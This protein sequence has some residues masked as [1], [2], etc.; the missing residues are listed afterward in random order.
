MSSKSTFS[1]STSK[2]YAMALYELSKESSELDKVE[3][4]MKSLEKI[5]N[6]SSDFKEMILNPMIMK[7]DKRNVIYAIS[8]HNNFP[9]NFKKFLGFLA[10]KNRLFFLNKIIESFLSLVS[11]TKGELKAKLISAK[12]LSSEEILDW[13]LCEEVSLN[14]Y[15][16]LGMSFRLWLS[17]VGF[18][19][20][21]AI[22]KLVST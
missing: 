8:D 14:P 3:E 20:G 10:D 17:R 6:E 9:K 11:N 4:G 7:E 18:L 19:L 15:K 2:S 5:L 1:S 13:G 16:W 12:K 21:Q 22:Q